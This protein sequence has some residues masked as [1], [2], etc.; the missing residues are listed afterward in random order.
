MSTSVTIKFNVKSII[1]DQFAGNALNEKVRLLLELDFTSFSFCF[2]HFLQYLNIKLLPSVVPGG[3]KEEESKCGTAAQHNVADHVEQVQ[4][5]G[6]D[7]GGV[8]TVGHG[9][10]SY[11]TGCHFLK[12]E[13]YQKYWDGIFQNTRTI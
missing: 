4:P 10:V 1:W 13:K 2:L 7:E 8:A 9:A 3:E 6:G 11:M 12:V 5:D